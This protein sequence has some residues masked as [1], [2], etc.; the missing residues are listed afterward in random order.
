MHLF[1][2]YDIPLTK[3]EAVSKTLDQL[4]SSVFSGASSA[5]ASATSAGLAAWLKQAALRAAGEEGLAENVLSPPR[6]SIIRNAK[7]QAERYA[8]DQNYITG[9]ETIPCIDTSGQSFAVW[10]NLVYLFP[11]TLLFVRFFVKSYTRRGAAARNQPKKGQAVKAIKDAAHGTEKGLD[12]AGK[13]AENGVDNISKEINGSAKGAS[14]PNGKSNGTPRSRKVSDTINKQW[15]RFE[16]G[17]ENAVEAVKNAGKQTL[18]KKSSQ[19]TD[20]LRQLWEE[21]SVSERS[22]SPS[23]D[24]GRKMMESAEEAIED[25]KESAGEEAKDTMSPSETQQGTDGASEAKQE[26]PKQASELEQS[27]ADVAKDA[28]P[29]QQ[30]PT[31]P[32]TSPEPEK[33]EEED[34]SATPTLEKIRSLSP[35]KQSKLPRPKSREPAADRAP[36]PVKK[37]SESATPKLEAPEKNENES[38]SAS[39]KSSPNKKKKNKPKKLNQSGSSIPQPASG[40]NGNKPKDSSSSTPSSVTTQSSSRPSSSS[41][42]KPA[43]AAGDEVKSSAL[44]LAPAAPNKKDEAEAEMTKEDASGR[45]QSTN[46]GAKQDANSRADSKV[47][48]EQG[49]EGKDALQFRHVDLKEGGDKSE[50]GEG[51]RE[52][53]EGTSFA[54]AV[55]ES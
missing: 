40:A 47:E 3:A 22:K 26:S 50:S 30:Q 41:G 48:V 12:K 24:R 34:R 55:K 38:A 1:V 14:T 51:E 20:K 28:Y 16:K 33:T 45:E 35:Q 17:G 31:P 46:G 25:V 2:T 5:A 36:S 9:Y 54:E 52:V 13:A 10:L 21:G 27:W 23:Q 39:A 8:P 19:S 49:S 44:P 6:G 11:L 7:Q 37:E 32:E 4:A 53:K 15:E 29:K 42:P 18:Q 43:R